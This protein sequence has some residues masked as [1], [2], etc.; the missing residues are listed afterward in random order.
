MMLLKVI[1]VMYVSCHYLF[2]NHGLIF[3]N[4]NGFHDLTVLCLNVSNIVVIIVK[5]VD[6]RIIDGISTYKATHLL[7]NTWKKKKKI[8]NHVCNY[9]CQIYGLVQ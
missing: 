4:S 2:F 3:Q 9:S 6:Y 7:E 1:T 5:S 8:L